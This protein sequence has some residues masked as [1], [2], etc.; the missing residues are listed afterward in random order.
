MDFDSF[1][2]RAQEIAAAIPKEFMSDV[3]SVDVHKDAK[4]H[5]FLPDIFTLGE[6]ETS[7]L[8]DAAGEERFR[9]RIHLWHGSFKALARSD[10]RFDWEGELR[11]TIEHEVQ[12]HIEDRAGIKD[13]SDEDDL[14]EAHARFRADRP[15]PA[16]WYRMGDEIEPHLWA[17]DLDLFLELDVRRKEWDALRGT[18][19]LLR[20]MGEQVEFEIP[21][22]ADPSE[23][24]TF[25]GEGLFEGDDEGEEGSGE[26]GKSDSP[27]LSGDLHVIPRVR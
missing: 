1:S 23:V 20:L 9:S 15:V 25:E 10:P 12:N 18:R 19:L 5:P 11:E 6:C 22:D 4:P 24:L 26:E 17:V 27:G 16:G 3:E 13:L 14:F 21:R 2:K 8:S 7:P